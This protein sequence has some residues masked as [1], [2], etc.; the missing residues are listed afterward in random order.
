MGIVPYLAMTPVELTNC[1]ALP[2]K[3]GYMA[4][5]FSLYGTGLQDLPDQLPKGSLLILDDRIPALRQDPQCVVRDLEAALVV[6][7]CAG[8]LLDFQRPGCDAMVEAIISRLPGTVVSERYAQA[9]R[10]PVFLPPLPLTQPL[11]EYIAPWK[12]REIWLDAAVDCA[13]I[14]VTAQGS[15]LHPCPEGGDFPHLDETL[16]CRYRLELQDNAA[17]FILY[18]S[19]EDVNALFKEAEKLGISHAVGLYQ[20]LPP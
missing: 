3:I 13:A 14:T 6:L 8:L 5:H 18:R 20:Q 16:H 9:Y 11:S 7:E 17:K 10:C 12:G 1:P 2:E 4:C 19:K 15:Q